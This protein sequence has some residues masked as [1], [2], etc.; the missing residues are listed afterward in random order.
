MVH[1][2][3]ICKLTED[4]QGRVMTTAQPGL[5]A[6]HPSKRG[7]VSDMSGLCH[8]LSFY[9]AA[10]ELIAA[11]NRQPNLSA[12][13][14]CLVAPAWPQCALSHICTHSAPQEQW[15]AS[16]CLTAIHSVGHLYQSA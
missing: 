9:S 16:C 5:A 12:C 4:G 6:N 7:Y 11:S 14:R 1:D 15:H 10:A 2:A 8:V 13:C 3:A